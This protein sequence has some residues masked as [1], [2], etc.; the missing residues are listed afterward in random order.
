VGSRP[1]SWRPV[2]RHPRTGTAAAA[3]NSTGAQRLGLHR[4]PPA[5]V[6]GAGAGRSRQERCSGSRHPDDAA[7]QTTTNPRVKKG[8]PRGRTRGLPVLPGS[9]S[10]PANRRPTP[11]D[12]RE[13]ATAVSADATSSV[14]VRFQSLRDCRLQDFNVRLV[15]QRKGNLIATLTGTTARTRNAPKRSDP[16]RQGRSQTSSP[17]SSPR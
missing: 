14:E 16:L 12:L 17:D 4:P 1:D 7:A 2:S 13:G 10:E 6:A 8:T 9:P 5:A 3:G 15:V 11:H